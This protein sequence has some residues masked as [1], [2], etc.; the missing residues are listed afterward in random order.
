VTGSTGEDAAQAGPTPPRGQGSSREFERLMRRLTVKLNELA[1]TGPQR[2]AMRAFNTVAVVR[3]LRQADSAVTIRDVAVRTGLPA[4]QAEAA[5]DSLC[6]DGAAERD[7][8]GRTWMYRAA[9]RPPPASDAPSTADEPQTDSSPATGG[10]RP[11]DNRPR[12]RASSAAARGDNISPAS[13]LVAALRVFRVA[14]E[15]KGQ[16]VTVAAAPGPPLPVACARSADGTWMWSWRYGSREYRHPR[17]D[18]NGAARG[19]AACLAA[20]ATRRRA[21]GEG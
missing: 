14:A 10:D 13:A 21:V 1:E 4:Y 8:T 11:A 5:L 19:I 20:A 2:E 16:G 3:V 9:K 12:A 6:N 15:V 7:T 18:P 17:D